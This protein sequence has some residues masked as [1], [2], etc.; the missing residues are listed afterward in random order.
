MI[1]KGNKQ[2]H[3]L[4]YVADL[5]SSRIFSP[6]FNPFPTLYHCVNLFSAWAC[7][8]PFESL[9]TRL[10]FKFSVRYIQQVGGFKHSERSKESSRQSSDIANLN[11]QLSRLLARMMPKFPHWPWQGRGRSYNLITLYFDNLYTL[12]EKAWRKLGFC[13]YSEKIARWYCGAL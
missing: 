5:R 3:R 12:P 7:L 9:I 4:S 2:C 8:C 1:V 11:S 6:I 13:A 10:G